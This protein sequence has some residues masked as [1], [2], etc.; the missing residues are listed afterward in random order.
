VFLL[1]EHRGDLRQAVADGGARLVGIA[2]VALFQRFDV[3]EQLALEAEQEKA[4]R[5]RA[6]PGRPAS[7]ADAESGRRCIR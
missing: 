7:A 4:A 6:S 2:L 1:G 5:A 3:R